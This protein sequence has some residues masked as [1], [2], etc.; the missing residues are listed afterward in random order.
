MLIVV[1]VIVSRS[2]SMLG[3]LVL[4]SLLVEHVCNSE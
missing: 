2:V 4:A 3:A 1:P